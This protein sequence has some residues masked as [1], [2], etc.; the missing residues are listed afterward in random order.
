M[1]PFQQDN[2]NRYILHRKYLYD[3]IATVVYQMTGLPVYIERVNDNRPTVPFA[4]L[5]LDQMTPLGYTFPSGIVEGDDDIERSF[6]TT[7]YNAIM[8][9]RTFKNNANAFMGLIRSGLRSE[10][11]NS[12]LSDQNVGF[13]SESSIDNNT[14]ILNVDYEERATYQI[15]LDTFVSI[16]NPDEFFYIDKVD[17]TQI[18]KDCEGNTITSSNYLVDGSNL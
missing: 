2:L 4:T 16:V 8:T 12:F 3:T 6:E 11:W 1:T 17:I 15:T 7:H 14:T 10:K 5:F 18:I 13:M 9:I